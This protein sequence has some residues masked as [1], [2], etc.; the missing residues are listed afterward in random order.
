LSL[1]TFAGFA[2]IKASK[3]LPPAALSQTRRPQ[4]GLA[5]VVWIANPPRGH[6]P[7]DAIDRPEN[8]TMP[9]LRL[10]SFVVVATT[11][12]AFLPALFAFSPADGQAVKVGP[13]IAVQ[14]P[15]KEKKND[16]KQSENKQPEYN[17]GTKFSAIKLVE[18]EEFQKNIDQAVDAIDGGAWQDA[19]D[20][21]QAIL[22]SKRDVFA[23]IEVTD[24]TTGAKK[25]HMVSVKFQANNL[26]AAMPV[27]G[28]T[29]YELK[30]GAQ[31]RHLLDQARKTGNREVLAEVATRYR[32]TKA[33]MEANDLLATS[34]LDRGDYFPAALRYER[35][36]GSSPASAKI[37][38]LTLF[39]ATL[40]FRRAGD[41]F[42]KKTRELEDV[43]LAR[44][45]ASGGLALAN[46]QVATVKQVQAILKEGVKAT[47]ANPH[48]WPLVHG[49]VA[50]NA[51]AKGSPPMLDYVV[52]SRPTFMEISEETGQPEA[53]H[54]VKPLFEKELER[55]RNNPNR[56]LLPGGFPIAANGILFY[57]TYAGITG[58][59]LHDMLDKDGKVEAPAGSVHW[60]STPFLG[61]LG[62]IF[63][64]GNMKMSLGTWSNIYVQNSWSYLL[65]ENSTVGT[66]TTDNRNIYAVDDL[67]LPIPPN[68]LAP[69]F[70]FANSAMTVHESLKKLVQENKLRAFN[71][72]SGK[73]A[74]ELSGDANKTDEFTNSHFLCAPI[75]VGGKL[76]VLNEKNSGDLR[77]VCLDPASGKIIG[78]PQTLGTVKSDH[79]YQKDIARRVNA[80]HLAYAEG[81][82]VCPTNA[83]EILG[84]DLLSQSLGWAYKYREK[85]MSTAANVG[86][87]GVGFVGPGGGF[88]PPP[89][90]GGPNQLNWTASINDSNWRA[91]PP[92]IVDGKVVFTAPDS[93]AVCC[94]SLRDGSEIWA[95]PQQ[96]ADLFLAGVFQGKV[97]IAGKNSIRALRLVDGVQAW[98]V[99]ATGDMP[100]GQGVASNNI[101]YLPLRKGEICAVDLNGWNIQ[102]HN[103]ASGPATVIG[104]ATGEG[105]GG[106]KP[107]W[108]EPPGNLVF[109]EGTVLSQTPTAIVA[110]PQ[111]AAKLQDAEIAYNKDASVKNLLARGELRLADGQVQKAANDLLGVLEKNPPKD[112]AVRAQDRL[113][114]ALGD[115]L[116][117]DFAGAAPK[118]L[119]KYK[120]LTGAT[121]NE[122]EKQR[123]EA[124]Y[125]RIVGQGREEQGKLVEAFLAFKD[126]GASPLFK[127]EGIPSMEDP[128]YKVPVN[129]WLRGRISAMFARATTEQ[130]TALDKKIGEEWQAVKEKNDLAAIRQFT[131]MFDVPVAVGREARLELANVIIANKAKESFLEA[132]L[133]LQQ[134]FVPAYRKDVQVGAKALEALARLETVK[135]TDEALRQ[136][137]DYYRELGKEFGKD[138]VADGKTGAQMVEALAGDPRWKPF[139]DQPAKVWA[140]GEIKHRELTG[141]EVEGIK[142]IQGYVFQPAGDVPPAIQ[143]HRL[144]LDY[145]IQNNPVLRYVDAANN[146]ERWS[147]PL[148]QSVYNYQFFAYLYDQNNR[149][150]GFHPQ[151]KFR[152]YHVKGHLAVIQVAMTVYGIDLDAG[153]VLWQHTLYDPNKVQSLGGWQV[154][155]DEQGRMWVLHVSQPGQ[156]TKSRVGQIGTVQATYVALVTQ[157]GLVVVDPLRGKPLWT[158]AGLAANTEVFGDDQYIFYV[159]TPEGAAVSIGRCL[160]ASDGQPVDVPD[161]GLYYR[162]Q[163]RIFAGRQI[164]TAEPQGK[165]LTM[166]LLDVPTGKSAWKRTFD[167]DPAVLH[168]EDPDQCGVIERDT[169]KLILLNAHTGQEIVTANMKQFRIGAEDLKELDQPLLLD[170][171]ENFFVALNTNNANKKMLSSNVSNNFSSGT[172]CLPV[173]GWLCCLDRKGDFLWHGH[174]RFLNQM[175]V[176]EQFKL[177]PILLF[178]SRYLEQVP[179]GGAHFVART[180]SLSKSD[181]K[182]IWWSPD[183]AT[184]NANAQFQA[185]NIDL[186]AG[187]INMIGYQNNKMVVQQHYVSGMER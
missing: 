133:N 14:F 44:M 151:A 15:I 48:D 143:Q 150:M 33:G 20:Y 77:V 5:H 43:L 146:K 159:E 108:A 66:L 128:L 51:Q 124:R 117:A 41:S 57:R 22:D 83:G 89:G 88:V 160:R 8:H 111:L 135:G 162:N 84:V 169:G 26:L 65:F 134:L 67:A 61:A 113:Y 58:V 174:D 136:A 97:V 30:F 39:K 6:L 4:Y 106:A 78:T 121:D 184:G 37:S 1:P 59:Y 158:R 10:V 56:P 176:V 116:Q 149:P 74:W 104:P 3:G 68:Y 27:Q 95:A 131:G 132:E 52:W 47:T 13:P 118:Y 178:S 172:R 105:K 173:N 86:R 80:I 35:L 185:F 18:D 152:F 164:L 29:A 130:R 177:L 50:R 157:K 72:D 69:N 109:Y 96:D 93:N 28:L 170:D 62:P 23:R 175:I 91:S 168:T 99:L 114:E 24:P 127:D 138:I 25:G 32:H 92:V 79:G 31:A 112:I 55:C 101:Y 155:I 129:L 123:R 19:C 36:L 87:G 90:F 147:A 17:P 63:D 40:A 46:G 45:K 54:E 73:I 11:L 156:Q 7:R 182:A 126:Y 64:D 137:V 9:N 166:R 53:G 103:R 102:A 144:V 21:L 186:S 165:S 38:D 60:R 42:A 115:L 49:N 140:G 76:Y 119:D 167:N 120:E 161:F 181:G 98:P 110:Y 145:N 163:Q 183:S 180:G 187:T 153:K 139:L 12:V 154:A 125:W 179:G 142:A 85:P 100:S 82:L 107:A 148:G 2:T 81:I 94:I 34:F 16:I 141:K 122:A 75:A 70:N 71:I 171:G